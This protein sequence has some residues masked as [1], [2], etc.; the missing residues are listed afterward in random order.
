MKKININELKKMSVSECVN[1][2]ETSMEGLSL[3]EV[4]LK[5]EQ[6]GTNEMPK[7][8]KDSLIFLI[9]KAIFNPFNLILLGL[10]TISLFTDVIYASEKDFTTVFIIITMVT[11]STLIRIIQDHKSAKAF[12]SL[13]KMIENK[14]RIKRN[15]LEMTIPSEKLVIGDLVLLSVGEIL[16]ADVRI[17]AE[18]Q[19]YVDESALTGESEAILKNSLPDYADNLLD[20][21]NIAFMGSVVKSGHA[22]GIVVRLCKDTFYGE[23]SKSL[24]KKKEATSFEKGIA[25]VSK[26]LISFMLVMVPIVFLLNG[27][28]TKNWLS[29]FL[30]AIAIAVGLTPEMLP[31]IVTTCLA[32]GSTQMGKKKTIIKNMNVIQNFG[33]MDI[34]C[35]DKTGTLTNNHMELIDYL[36]VNGNEAIEVLKYASINA[37]YQN[38]YQNPLDE[39]ILEKNKADDFVCLGEVPYDFERRMLSVFGKLDNKAISI[40]KG[41]FNEVISRSSSIY[42]NGVIKPINDEN[43]NRLNELNIRFLK[44][45]K[46]VLAVAIRNDLNDNIDYDF[47]YENNLILVGLLTFSDEPKKSAY[48]AIKAL[49]KYGVD[50][51]ILTGD[52]K[53]NTIFVCKEIGLKNVKAIDGV[54]IAKWNEVDFSLN[55]E[56]YQVFAK[57][58][59]KQKEQIVSAL[60]KNGHTVGFMGDGINDVPALKMA[61][62]PISVDKAQDIAKDVAEVVLLEN[63]LMVLEEGIIE[64]R[65]IYVN[66]MKYIKMTASSNFGNMLSVLAASAFLPFLPMLSLQLLLL[67]LVYDISSMALPWDN[68]DEKYILSPRKWDARDLKRFMLWMGPVSSVFDILTYL[69]LYFV[70]CPHVSGGGYYGDGTNQAL[71]IAVFHAGWFIESMWTQTFVVHFIRTEKIPFV[72]SMPSKPLIVCSLLGVISLTIL[73]YTKLGDKLGFAALPG[74]FY[75]YLVGIVAM[76]F[77]LVSLVKYLY[78]ERFKSLL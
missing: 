42:D 57:L 32:K 10:A 28:T 43:I 55:V 29:A 66:M 41:A 61:D 12:K 16:P 7:R 18:N 38:G 35:T 8:K 25:R 13:A 2:L 23:M 17:I 44:E 65:K 58:T 9:I 37:Y 56:K 39:A 20:S 72:G 71:F 50:V 1:Y 53:E 14:V 76:Y 40:T 49:K 31:M 78:V 48:K 3:E 60:K 27:F 54:E 11:L 73:P 52:T 26:L 33:A 77:A 22:K 75:I 62:V 30:F 68:V 74:E 59:P 64:G 70:I 5:Q 46:R 47:K 34:L 15:G 63:D 21:K 24:N 36:D 67:N 51:K 45:G 19:F 4:V 69:L 6:F